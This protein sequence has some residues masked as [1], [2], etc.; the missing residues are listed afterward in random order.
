MSFILDSKTRIMADRKILLL[1]FLLCCVT[2][3]IYTLTYFPGI[4]GPLPWVY[5]YFADGHY[6]AGRSVLFPHGPLA[7]MLYPLAMGN[8]LIITVVFS[9][10]SSFLFC[11]TFFKI[12]FR[13]KDENYLL[14]SLLLF[15]ILSVSDLQLILL[16]IAFLQIILFKLSEKWKHLILAVF[17]SVL[18]LYLKT[19]GGVLGIL[20]LGSFFIYLGV[21]KKE[22]KKALVVPLVYCTFFLIVWMSLYQ[23]FSGALTFVVGQVQLSLDNSEAVSF[24]QVN[25]WYLIALSLLSFIIIPF[26]TKTKTTRIAHGLLLLPLFGAWKHA[27]SRA[28]SIHVSGFLTA[29]TLFSLLLLLVENEKKIRVLVMCTLSVAFFALNMSVTEKYNDYDLKKEL[30]LAKPYHLYSIFFHYDSLKKEKNDLSLLSSH[31]AILPDTLLQLIGK[32]TSDVYPWN[33]T[34][35]A[36]NKLKWQPRPSLHSY[37]SYTSWLDEQNKQHILSDSSPEFILWEIG[38]L[39]GKLNSIDYRYLLNDAPKTTL[40]FFSHYQLKYKDSNYLLYEK[41]NKA[42][43]LN[44]HTI[45]PEKTIAYNKWISVPDCTNN[46][47]IRAKVKIKKSLL[48]SLKGFF[49]KGE[50]YSIYYET[51]DGKIH[52][53]KIVPKNAEDGVW[54]NPLILEPETDVTE[55]LVKKIKLVC[56]D[57]T[58]VTKDFRI[59]FEQIRFQE[60]VPFLK[61][62]F[63]KQDSIQ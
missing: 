6:L 20:L 45:A 47:I 22:F 57:S 52:S 17:F 41:T 53:H 54:I 1:S 58:M 62:C 60:K 21:I 23:T 43:T 8:N 26:V 51:E 7:F 37:A 30:N 46:C 3:P 36:L 40:A 34:L 33:Y 28:D 5:N 56:W 15:L 24:Y 55:P 10:I 14:P 50:S 27:M 35:I 18:N 42:A 29:L 59:T 31:S 11:F 63:R 61:K 16:G 2:F 4:D 49:Y 12:Y 9:F 32:K 48:G 25:N 44:T 13:E 38:T 39:G 19:Y